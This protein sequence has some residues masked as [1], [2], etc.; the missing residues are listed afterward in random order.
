M[1]LTCIDL[2]GGAG[3]WACAARGLPVRILATID[4]DHEALL[5]YRHNHPDIT[6]IAADVR[7][8]PLDVEALRGEIDVV[9]G[10]IPCE[11]ISKWR[12]F[13]RPSD[14][15]VRGWRDVLDAC[16]AF[17]AAVKP[18]W[19]CLEDTVGIIEHLPILTPY[20]IVDARSF[21]GQS[22]KRAFVGIFPAPVA[23]G[24]QQRI[25]LDHLRPGPHRLGIRPYRRTP[26]R[27][28]WLRADKHSWWDP[29]RSAHT[30]CKV[31]SQ[32]DVESVVVDGDRRRQL[33]WQEAARL[34]GFPED[35]VFIGSP[36]KTAKLI[37]QAIQIDLGRAILEA[38]VRAA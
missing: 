29:D 16:L 13:Q 4:S 6:A 3:G 2:C 23:N 10:G 31:T 1:T 18:R 34:Q 24:K 28:Q 33:E 25:L 26:Q 17:V 27:S 32:R 20:T 22:R 15:E 30:V 11:T 35:Y 7:A 14:A 21:S 5:T 8:M 19:S 36:T 12:Q 38:M 9:L 37:G